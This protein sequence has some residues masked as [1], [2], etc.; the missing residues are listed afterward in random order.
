M[1]KLKIL[2]PIV[3][4][5][6]IGGTL[7][8]LY[9]QLWNPLWN[10][11]VSSREEM[12]ERAMAEMIKLESLKT[13]GDIDFTIEEVGE[14]RTESFQISAD[15]L[16]NLDIKNAKSSSD[17][18]IT[19][20]SE[21][22]EFC[23]AGELRTIEGDLYFV[24]NR[25]PTIPFLAQGLEEF[26]NQWFKISKE[27]LT[28]RLQ[29]KIPTTTQS[30]DK[31]KTKEMVEE[32]V[33]ALKG[34]KFFKIEKDFGTEEIDGV[35]VNHL[36]VS[37]KKEEVK[38]VI[39]EFL[40]RLKKYLPEEEKV[41]YEEKLKEAMVSLPQNFEKF[42]S[43]VGPIT[44]EVWISRNSWLRRIKGEKEINLSQFEQFQETEAEQAKIK[45][46]IDFK[47]SD[48]NQELKIEAPGEF[49]PLEEILPSGVF[50][51]SPQESSLQSSG[52]F[53]STPEKNPSE[54]LPSPEE[55]EELKK[56]LE[57]FPEE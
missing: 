45:M 46:A 26:K 43:K 36:L 41:S 23:F 27:S 10:P 49:K 21:G 56:L 35:K 11:F 47:F 16:N 22:I 53:S 13:E 19:L 25:L 30:T 17:F 5:V 29:G 40:P 8:A 32:F 48:F 12:V 54:Q 34:R 7:L 28:Q 9:T 4:V 50:G 37:L 20:G 51:F 33:E 18:E 6:A 38:E 24:F 15:F 3:I 42:F 52:L 44:F 31:E 2:I 14:E 55:M 1:P 57:S 39:L